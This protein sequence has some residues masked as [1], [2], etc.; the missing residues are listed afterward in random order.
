MAKKTV[1]TLQTGGGKD[2][3]K[4]IKAVKNKKKQGYALDLGCGAGVDSKYLAKNGFKVIA[5]DNSSDAI[6]QAKKTC[7]ELSVKVVKA[8]I[9]NFKIEPDKYSLIISWNTLPFLRKK[10]AKKVLESIKK[11]LKKEGLF[12][13]SI[14]GEN[15]DW[16]DKKQ[17]SFWN[18]EEF[19]KKMK[20]VE[21]VELIEK[22][23]KDSSATGQVKF[24]HLI[25][26]V[27]KK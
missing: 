25:Q 26:G 22:Q 18:L 11:G 16:K 10:E 3:I 13:F 15:D 1:A 17:M 27:I 19:K 24:W 5:V 8:D 9:V 23:K 20:G 7:K 4:C 14:F 12:I 6:K 21:F 2:Y